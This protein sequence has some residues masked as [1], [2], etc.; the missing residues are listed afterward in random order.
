MRP[1]LEVRST[2]FTLI[3]L[4]V[5]V[6]IIGILA[7]IALPSYQE[8]VRKSRRSDAV[9]MFAK[10]QQAQQKW[11]ANNTSYTNN[12]GGDGLRLA[13]SN[14]VTSLTSEGG[15]YTLSISVDAATPGQKYTVTATAQNAQSQDKSSC[16]T[17]RL[18]VNQGNS[19]IYDGASGT[20]QNC[21]SK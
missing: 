7:A 20:N 4:M 10:I 14:S 12:F 17:L 9:V 1:R 11:R 2:G 8:Y 19:R 13:S 5:V 18:E 21:V 15:Y 6:A 3:E 16:R